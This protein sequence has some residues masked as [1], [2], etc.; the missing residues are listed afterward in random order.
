MR[1]QEI[2]NVIF[3]KGPMALAIEWML[4]VL[5]SLG[6]GRNPHFMEMVICIAVHS[7][8]TSG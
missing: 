2:K 7:R 1:A 4:N 5:I 8:R 6:I 3:S